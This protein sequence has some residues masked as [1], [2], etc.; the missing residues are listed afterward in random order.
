MTHMKYLNSLIIGVVAL[1][2]LGSTTIAAPI[3]ESERLPVDLR[4][5]RSW[6]EISIVPYLCIVTHSDSR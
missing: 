4:Q 5:P 6:F 2:A 3:P 1:I